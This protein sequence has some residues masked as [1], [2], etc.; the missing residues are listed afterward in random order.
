MIIS[1]YSI[2]LSFT[3]YYLINILLLLHIIYSVR[4]SHMHTFAGMIFKIYELC[5]INMNYAY[6]LNKCPNS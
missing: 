4:V 3:L 1:R 6:I 2:R 5:P